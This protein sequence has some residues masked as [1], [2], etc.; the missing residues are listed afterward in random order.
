MD[1]KY[2]PRQNGRQEHKNHL[3]LETI[4]NHK[5]KICTELKATSIPEFKICTELQASNKPRI[6]KVNVYFIFQ[7]L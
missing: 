7:K 4:T 6:Y 5:F 3:E 1:I 2:I